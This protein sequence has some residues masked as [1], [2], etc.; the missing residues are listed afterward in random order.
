MIAAHQPN[1]IP[2]PGFF[3]KII[4][5]DAMVFLDHVQYSDKTWTNRNKIKTPNGAN[6]LSVP[7]SLPKHDL[8]TYD[9]CID[10]SN[11]VWGRKH[12]KTLLMSYGKAK[13]FKRYAD[14]FEHLYSDKWNLLVDLN[15]AII[16]YILTEIGCSKPLVKSSSLAPNG[17][18]NE[19]LIDICKKMEA[20]KFLSGS[21]GPYMESKKYERESITVIYQHYHCPQYPQ[22]HGPFEQ[23]LSVIDLLFNCGPDTF[24]LIM[25]D[26]ETY[27]A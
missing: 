19:M 1:Y 24:D 3:H 25:E 15:I 6:W 16:Q 14:F 11:G 23:N 9:V 5:S 2:W 22:L 21:G 10:P 17:R 20:D 13:H 4:A 7:V 12:W 18:S 27:N 26:Q 8:P